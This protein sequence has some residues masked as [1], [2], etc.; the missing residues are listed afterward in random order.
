MSTII[1][2][3]E[4]GNFPNWNFEEGT[5]R[6][7]QTGSRSIYVGD[8][9]DGDDG[10]YALKLGGKWSSSNW[11][12]SNANVLPDATYTNG[13]PVGGNMIP[14]DT[15][16]SWTLSYS[17]RTLNQDTNGNNANNY[18][19][20]TCWDE[21][22]E[23][24]ELRTNGPGP[25]TANSGSRATLTRALSAGDTSMYISSSSGWYTGT[26]NYAKT[27]VV[28]PAGPDTRYSDA[29]KYSRVS[30]YV[31]GVY[32]NDGGPTSIGGGEYRIDFVNYSNGA[33][34]WP[35][36]SGTYSFPIGTPVCNS[37]A[38]GTYNY[39]F[40]NFSYGTSWQTKSVTMTGESRNSGAKFR[41][42][43]KYIRAMILYNY[44]KS[45]AGGTYPYAEALYDRMLFIANPNSNTYT[46]TTPS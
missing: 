6:G 12:T 29:Y 11:N 46:I 25:G 40:S 32:M 9:F 26:T 34:S 20:F 38:G 10:Q 43:T 15:T 45:S 42:G 35:D 36:Y 39:A 14:V 28:Y 19:G 31:N 16:K 27:I 44:G 7:W 41:W 18:L 1:G 2:P 37:S 4:F 33:A 24:I 17:M 30:S 23:F 21:N 5:D 8:S 3:T 13:N 22:G